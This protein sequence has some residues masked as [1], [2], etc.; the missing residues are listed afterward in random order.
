[1]TFLRL[2]CTTAILLAAAP[3]AAAAQDGPVR[4]PAPRD[5]SLPAQRDSI[6]RSL[7]LDELALTGFVRNEETGEPVPGIAV[8]IDGSDRVTL[9]GVDGGYVLR[10]LDR[11]PSPARPLMARACEPGRDYLTEVREVSLLSRR[12]EIVVV[13]DGVAAPKPGYAARLDFRVRPRPIPF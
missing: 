3:M 6:L 2:A 11:I 1:M 13:T 12:D 10:F 7:A 4:C 8:G 9:T 5:H